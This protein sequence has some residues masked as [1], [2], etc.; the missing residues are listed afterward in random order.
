MREQRIFASMG[1]LTV[2]SAI[3]ADLILLPAVLLRFGS[4]R[5]DN[6]SAP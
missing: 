4:P 3:V 2:A 6:P 1:A 5:S